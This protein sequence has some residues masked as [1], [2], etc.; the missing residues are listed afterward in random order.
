MTNITKQDIKKISAPKLLQWL[1][2]NKRRSALD[3]LVLLSII[4]NPGSSPADLAG[5]V[6]GDRGRSSS[7]NKSIQRLIDDRLVTKTHVYKSPPKVS[8]FVVDKNVK[9]LL[10]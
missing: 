10:W 3:G 9:K 4:N 1:Y 2:T 7:V 6:T 5:N 8:I